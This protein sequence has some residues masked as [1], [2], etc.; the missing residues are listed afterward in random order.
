MT[1]SMIMTNSTI[2]NSKDNLP[3]HI[4]IFKVEQ[5]DQYKPLLLKAIDQMISENNIQLNEKGY[6]YDYNIPKVERTYQKLID[7]LLMPYMYELSEPYG[8]SMDLNKSRTWWFQQYFQNSDFGWHQHSGH[9]A[10]VYY[11]ELP[12]MTEATE[13]LNYGQFNVEEGD[14]IFF[15]TFL[16]HRAPIIK[17]NQRKTIIATNV[18]FVVDRKMIQQYGEE[19]FRYR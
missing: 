3:D 2:S 4:H 1:M 15:P 17:S 12:E 16:T 8:L 13:F 10:C 14:V 19:S 6:Y 5:H 7:S 9:W 11:L 18:N